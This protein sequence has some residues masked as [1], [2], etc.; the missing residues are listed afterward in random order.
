MESAAEGNGRRR[1]VTKRVITTLSSCA[2]HLV[3]QFWWSTLLQQD[4]QHWQLLT[5]ASPC[6]AMACNSTNVGIKW[7]WPNDL[8]LR[9]LL[10][11]PM[12]AKWLG[13]RSPNVTLPHFTREAR[14][15]FG[16]RAI[17]IEE[18]IC[19]TLYGRISQQKVGFRTQ[20]AIP[21]RLQA[22]SPR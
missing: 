7:S 3:T 8:D 15:R 11:T 21:Q 18:K 4:P 2:R 17:E 10:D 14:L 20:K 6:H 9:R 16:A 1:T 5:P 22:L 19:L 13:S 12:F